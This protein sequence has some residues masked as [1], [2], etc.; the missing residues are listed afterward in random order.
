MNPAPPAGLDW[1]S[2]LPRL[3]ARSLGHSLLAQDAL[4]PRI[5]EQA[6]SALVDAALH[7]G[8]ARAEAIARD[9][10]TDPWIIARRLGLAIVNS[11]ADASFGTVL[12]FAEYTA[13]PPR[14]TL[15]RDAIAAMNQRL[16][17]P[18]LRVLEA[19]DCARTVLAHELYHHLAHSSAQ[20]SLSRRYRVKQFRIGRWNWSSGVAALEEIAAGAFAQALL[21]LKFHP[22][23][24]ELL[25]ALGDPAPHGEQ[26]ASTQE[27]TRQ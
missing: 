17:H 24:F 26:R 7:D 4:F 6:R 23:L 27:E 1:P 9:L 20:P 15:Y 19:G 8:S 22:R 11:N 21:D 2:G 5:P 10:G 16:A 14:I 13:A 3:T 12:V 25:C 18:L